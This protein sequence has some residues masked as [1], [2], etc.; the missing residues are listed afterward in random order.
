MVRREKT[1]GKGDNMKL[2]KDLFD[3]R[4]AQALVLAVLLLIYGPSVGLSEAQAQGAVN[5]ILVYIVGRGIH[6]AGIA[7]KLS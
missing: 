5:A 1:Q 3:S 4:K 2:L 6:D 7:V